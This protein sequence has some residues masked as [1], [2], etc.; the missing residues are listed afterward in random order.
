MASY[1]ISYRIASAS[2]IAHVRAQPLQTRAALL[3]C[4]ELGPRIRT[5]L[6]NQRRVGAGHRVGI[7]NTPREAYTTYSCTPQTAEPTERATATTS[8]E[9]V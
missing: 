6:G 2:I 9:L 3:S 1:A 8:T 5:I 4:Q 7:Q